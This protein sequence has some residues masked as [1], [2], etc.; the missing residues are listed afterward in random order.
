MKSK[1]RFFFLLMTWVMLFVPSSALAKKFNQADRTY[2]FFQPIANVKPPKT[3]K[4][5]ANQNPIDA[6]VN[7]RLQSKG[8]APA[9]RADRRTLIRRAY[10][11][12]IG[13]PPTPAQIQAFVND[14]S[15]GAFSRLVNRLLKSPRYG[16]RW[17]RHWLDL[18]RYADSDGYK[19]DVYR[20]HIYRYRDY[21]INAFNADKPYDRFIHEQ[22]AGDELFPESRE[23]LVATGYLR[24]W[25][26]ED[27]QRNVAVQWQYIMDDITGITGEVFMGL[28]M[29]CAQCH[30]H[31]FDPILQR[32]YFGLQAFFAAV[33]P[34]TDAVLA[35]PKER[36][37]YAKQLA[38]WSKATQSVR[39][40]IDKI[41]QSHHKPM[42]KAYADTFPDYA[43]TMFSKSPAERSMYERQIV[44]FADIQIREKSKGY[45]AKIKG[46]T[47]KRWHALHKE[48][49][50]FDHL[51]PK[52]Y[53]TVTTVS[54]IG[55]VAPTIYLGGHT[56]KKETIVEPQ[57]LSILN[58]KVPQL[59][60]LKQSPNTTGRR[61]AFAKWLTDPKNPITARVMANRIWQQH[62]G[63]GIVST[64][65][66]FGRQGTKPTHPE[67][68]DYLA[69]RFM[70]DGWSIKKLIRLI[71]TSQTYQRTS[72][73]D[74]T[75]EARRHDPSNKLLWRMRVRRLDAEQ[76]RDA[77]L[78]VS[79]ELQ[80][81][82]GG[83]AVD[84]KSTRRSV[85]LKNRRN[86]RSGLLHAFDTPDM[87]NSC[88][89]R[90]TTTT[91]IQALAM[92][93][94][95]WSNWR[96]RA[97]VRSLKNQKIVDKCQLVNHAYRT[98]L[99][100]PATDA[101]IKAGVEFIQTEPK[102]GLVDFCHTLLNAN[103]FIYID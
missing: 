20:P 8:I 62:F 74:P 53:P 26:Y 63:V 99:G 7:A 37:A 70:K 43:Q 4:A 59:I 14:P 83:P 22:L 80:H 36:Q 48:L 49:A 42:L 3:P 77:M 39:D 35:T 92:I 61:A 34:K 29:R 41:R 97:F 93:N 57:F 85:Y 23:A 1:S 73:Y 54:D 87:H 67:L 55:A 47:R 103:E 69:R 52:P 90:Q 64:S 13:L 60:F 32:D 2:W 27:N 38:K 30:D 71:M 21:V 51:K 72:V 88:A 75:T 11:D 94:G 65:N 86:D 81:Q 66:D 101:E 16:E 25:P 50:K 19:A 91:P 58:W 10:F 33:Y 78:A 96:A 84:F 102:T 56:G 79:K 5:P 68:L 76:I 18:V 89:R 28:G 12:L 100:R 46:K 31:K 40:Q 15:P 45:A 24:L 44:H 95:Y 9:P 6:F 82:I 17:A 98:A